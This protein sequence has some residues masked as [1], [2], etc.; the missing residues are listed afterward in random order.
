MMAASARTS[1]M[2]DPTSFSLNFGC[3]A[4]LSAAAARA[5]AAWARRALATAAALGFFFPRVSFGFG[6]LA[7][8]GAAVVVAVDVWATASTG[9]P[10]AANVA[11][12]QISRTILKS[13]AGV[14][15][16]PLIDKLL[17]NVSAL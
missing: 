16:K 11:N 13:R 5:R 9:S 14:T 3:A 10:T 12:A 1:G 2:S 8:R 15:G 17:Q 6:A 7:P 4:S